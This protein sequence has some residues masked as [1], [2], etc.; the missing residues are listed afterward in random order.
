MIKGFLFD[1]YGTVCD[2]HTPMTEAIDSHATSK[3]M[4]V[5]APEFARQWR[6]AYAVET[7]RRASSGEPFIPLQVL[8]L[9]ALTTVAKNRFSAELSDVEAERLNGVWRRL[10]PW[11]DTRRGLSALR[12]IAPCATCSNGGAVDMEPLAEVLDIEWDAVLGSEASGFYKPHSQTYLRSVD[13]LKIK[14]SE[15]VMVAAHQKD[16]VQ[17]RSHGLLTA[18]INRPAEFGGRGMGEEREVTGDWDFVVSSFLEL[19][20]LIQTSR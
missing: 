14:P 9:D 19:A 16:L 10:R 17:A 3:G 6:R 2:W 8:T 13:A 1:V 20:E 4:V 18:F 11:P 5:D 7:A 15:C 12:A